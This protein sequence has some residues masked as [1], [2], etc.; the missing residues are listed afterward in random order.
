MRRVSKIAALVATMVIHFASAVALAQTA[1]AVTRGD[2]Y[3]VAYFL[4]EEPSDLGQAILP[5]AARDVAVARVSLI[6]RPRYL[7]RREPEE[8]ALPPEYLF[9]SRLSV[10]RVLSGHA[11]AGTNFDVTFAKP[12][13][14]GRMTMVPLSRDEINRDYFVIAY[15]DEDGQRHLA[16][17]P[18]SEAKYRGWEAAAMEFVRPPWLPKH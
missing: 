9:R 17:Y 8:D 18:I 13:R 2:S 15:V 12:N 7:V 4:D 10:V 1:Q 11:A 16:G 3:L 6:G 5:T 14:S